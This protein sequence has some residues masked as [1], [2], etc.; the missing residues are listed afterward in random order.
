MG[1]GSRM[2]FANFLRFGRWRPKGIHLAPLGPQAQSIEPEDAHQMSK[3]HLDFLTLAL[4]DSKP[5]SLR[6]RAPSREL[7]H[8]WSARSC[9]WGNLSRRQ[10]NQPS[11]AWLNCRRPMKFRRRRADWGS[12]KNTRSQTRAE[13]ASDRDFSSPSVRSSGTALFF[14]L[15]SAIAVHTRSFPREWK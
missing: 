5:R 3:E 12:S 9:D 1:A 8:K 4:G 15:C 6:L 7:L 10:F 11:A 13:R 2:S 14:L